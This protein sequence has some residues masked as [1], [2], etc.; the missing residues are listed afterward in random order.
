MITTSSKVLCTREHE[1]REIKSDSAVC[2]ARPNCWDNFE[3][4]SRKKNN[5]TAEMK[6]IYPQFINCG[7]SQ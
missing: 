5:F 7:D 3:F 2:Y 4:F 6:V 1:I